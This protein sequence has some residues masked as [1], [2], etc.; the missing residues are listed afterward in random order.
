MPRSALTIWRREQPPSDPNHPARLEHCFYCFDSLYSE[1]NSRS[2]HDHKSNDDEVSI[3][4]ESMIGIQEFP[5][6]VTWNISRGGEHH[7]LRG[8]IGN[9]SPSPLN[10]GLKEYAVVSALK[11]RRFSPISFVDFK[12]LSCTVSLLHSFE[13]CKNFT[14]WT[15]GKH[16]IYI[17]IPDPL[18]PIDSTISS[19]SITP[20][21]SNSEGAANPTTLADVLSHVKE[22]VSVPPTTRNR[23]QSWAG[24]KRRRLLS[25]TYLPDVAAEQGWSKAE[26]IDSAIRKAGWNGIIT[27]ALRNSLII[28]RYQ[29]SKWTVTYQEWKEWRARLGVKSPDTA[30]T[31]PLSYSAR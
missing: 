8:C 10:E 6:F 29:S 28:E 22:S 12:K 4:L 2:Q 19:E 18:Q 9:F 11:D 7:R 1:L 24:Q 15:V 21:D 14:D 26:T 3:L 31:Q 30:F 25:A 13:D 5:L 23:P 17:H 27:A 16:G 20:S